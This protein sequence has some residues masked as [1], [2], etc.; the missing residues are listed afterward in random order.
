M[1]GDGG[2]DMRAAVSAGLMRR[3]LVRSDFTKPEDEALADG[4]FDDFLSAARAAA[5]AE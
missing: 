1:I 4:V 5:L 3:W 2:S